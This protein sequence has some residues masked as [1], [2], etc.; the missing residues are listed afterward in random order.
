MK[1][2]IHKQEVGEYVVF[3][4]VLFLLPGST[5]LRQETRKYFPQ[6]VPKSTLSETKDKQ[7]S[8]KSETRR[9]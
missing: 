4:L 6:A 7:Q 3:K 1:N 8:R 2:Q 5:M 9:K